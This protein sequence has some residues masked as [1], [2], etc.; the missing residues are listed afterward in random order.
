MESLSSGGDNSSQ[1]SSLAAVQTRMEA[2]NV[3]HVAAPG[4]GDRSGMRPFDQLQKLLWLDLSNNR[5]THVAANYLPRS[6]VTM[7]LSS[8]LLSVFP[9][10]LFE[11]LPELRIVSLRDNL[12]RSVF[13]KQTKTEFLLRYKDN[14]LKNLTFHMIL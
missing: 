9:Q 4:S 10:Q 8:N 12:L 11:Q 2:N 5:I 1:P 13:T 7:D 3:L 6:L 14:F